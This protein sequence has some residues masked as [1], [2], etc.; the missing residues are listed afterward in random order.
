MP[1]S[2]LHQR[3]TNFPNIALNEEF[4]NLAGAPRRFPLGT[5]GTDPI[6]D[7]GTRTV[8]LEIQRCACQKLLDVRVTNRLN[9]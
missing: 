3:T 8:H 1:I 6:A 9:I 4:H 7:T 2:P 5:L